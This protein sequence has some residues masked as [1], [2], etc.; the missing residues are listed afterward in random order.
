MDVHRSGLLYKQGALRLRTQ[1]V[2][3]TTQPSGSLDG[4]GL[5]VQAAAHLVACRADLTAAG[6]ADAHV[7]TWAIVQPG[8]GASCQL[9]QSALNEQSHRCWWLHHC[10]W[11][12][13]GP[14]GVTRLCH[15]G[16]WLLLLGA[17]NRWNHRALAP[18]QHRL[19]S[20]HSKS[21]TDF[22]RAV[23]P[24]PHPCAPTIKQ[25]TGCC[26]TTQ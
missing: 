17:W 3:C 15:M 2:A 21:H 4:T 26:Y 23:R 24:N 10:C 13:L 18:A 20:C 7:I 19:P 8:A 25:L 9:S 11:G 16:V 1:S 5:T 14:G 22:G 6:H 12:Q